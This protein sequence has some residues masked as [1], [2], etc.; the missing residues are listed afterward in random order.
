M[1]RVST[2]TSRRWSPC[3]R[4]LR[5]AQEAE[6]R[7]RQQR[8][9]KVPMRTSLRGVEPVSVPPRSRR[10]R[11]ATPLSVS[12]LEESREQAAPSPRPPTP[13][14]AHVPAILATLPNALTC[15]R[16]LLVPAL[17]L[18][19]SSHRGLALGVF[20]AAAA[21]DALDGILARRLCASSAFGRF[22]DP[23]ADKLIVSA[24]LV[25]L[26]SGQA[27]LPGVGAVDAGLVVTIIAR[28]VPRRGARAS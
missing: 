27:A 4:A 5:L 14:A 17:V 6:T 22:L 13:T 28:C 12:A 8:R 16:V 7:L 21:T 1:M 23:V 2:T 11:R 24:A 20:L 15:L 10:R 26:A 19:F 9:P 18:S 25:L 3:T